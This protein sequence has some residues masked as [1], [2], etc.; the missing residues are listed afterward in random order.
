VIRGGVCRALLAVALA[1]LAVAAGAASGAVPAARAA[2]VRTLAD[3]HLG[4][5]GPALAGDR[6]VYADA[7]RDSL[8]VLS[9]PVTGGPRSEL[10]RVATRSRF[11]DP[12]WNLASAPD[13]VAVQTYRVRRERLLAGPLTGP[14]QPVAHGAPARLRAEEERRLFAV[15]G[16]PLVLERAAGRPGSVR[17]MLRPPGGPARVLAFPRG[18]DLRTLAVAGALAAVVVPRA[19]NVSLIDLPAGTV[20]DRVPLGDLADTLLIDLAVSAGGDVALTIE[21]GSGHDFVGWAPAGAAG[22]PRIVVAGDSFGHLRT[23]GGRIA[24]QQPAGFD[25]A[26]VVV[27]DPSGPEPRV[28]FRGPPASPVIRDLDYDGTHVAWSTDSCQFIALAVPRASTRRVPPGRCVRTEVSLTTYAPPLVPG[29]PRFMRVR[30]RCLTAPGPRCRIELEAVHERTVG[31]LTAR[32]QVGTARVLRVRISRRAARLL[33]RDHT[34]RV[35]LY[36]TLRDPG[37]RARR[38][39]L[40]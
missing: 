30:A 5:G 10:A 6:V 16:G 27:L 14:L 39:F 19:R 3:T 24:M 21:D 1:A 37:G 13:G 4:A 23:A 28:L 17:A 29:R 31:R 33:Q 8:R 7:T 34:A 35:F 22:P 38:W 40:P 9:E 25:A 18:A 2:G 12:L 20:R 36:A 15:P 11:V 32:L 26:R